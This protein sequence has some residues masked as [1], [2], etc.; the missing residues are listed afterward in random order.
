MKVIL[1]D[2]DKSTLL[3]MKKMI[4]KILNIELVGS[5]Q[6]TVEAYRFLKNNKVDV[7]FV[8]I[9]LP[10]E[11]GL[12]F[13]R[14]VKEEAADTAVIFLTAHKEYALEAFEVQ[15]FDYIVKPIS[16]ARLES[17]IQRMK[18]RYLFPCHTKI[19]MDSPRLYA[20]CLGA[21]EVVGEDNRI[22]HFSSS[23]SIELLAY[24]LAKNGRFVS[25]WSVIE[26]VFRGM[27]PQNAET[28]LNTTVYKLRKAL[29]AHGM[30]SAI[31][32]HNESYKIDINDI[33]VDFIDFESRVTSFFGFNISNQE[34]ALN[35]EKLFAGELFGEKDYY[36]ALPQKE[37]LSEV[38]WSFAKRLVHYLLDG[39]QLTVALQILKKLVYLNELDEEVSCLLMRIYA[40]QKDRLSLE[41]Q[42]ER[43]KKVLRREL[44]IL[45]ENATINLYLSLTKSIK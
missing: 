37:R 28:Y 12:D 13:A 41:R 36:W 7:A 31:I 10:E 8:D 44:G 26:D 15:A 40:A 14:R 9:N 43:Y 39:N 22:V 19:N 6:R 34:E 42:Y 2:D 29:E 21:I 25:K 32:S 17:T 20:Y 1:V 35:T 27:P 33:Y 11:N 38:Y 45:P 4:S 24:L 23:K 5:F 3:I 18:Q 30:K 16:Q